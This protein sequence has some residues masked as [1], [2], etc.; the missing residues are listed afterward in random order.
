MGAWQTVSLYLHYTLP[1]IHA[2]LPIDSPTYPVLLP[3]PHTC[4]VTSLYTA[5]YMLSPAYTLPWICT[6]LPI[7]WPTYGLPCPTFSQPVLL[8]SST[9]LYYPSFLLHPCMSL[10]P[11]LP[12]LL[13]FHVLTPSLLLIIPSPPSPSSHFFLSF[14]LPFSPLRSLSSVLCLT[15]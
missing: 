11:F 1:Y 2:T 4:T 6:T 7:Y 8:P 9:L 14:L 13:L 5:L 3:Y 12:F 10:L 15:S